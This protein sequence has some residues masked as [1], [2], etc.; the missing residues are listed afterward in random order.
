[1]EYLAAFSSDGRWLETEKNVGISELPQNV[2]L[3]LSTKFETYTAD[4]AE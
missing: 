2:M 4:E 3:T 1:M